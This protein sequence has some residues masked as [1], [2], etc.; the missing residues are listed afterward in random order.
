MEHFTNAGYM[1]HEQVW[2][3]VGSNAAPLAWA[4]AEYIKLVRSY[5]VKLAITIVTVQAKLM[6]PIFPYIRV[7]VR[8]LSFFSITVRSIL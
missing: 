1:I 3:N 7:P 8:I 2:D 5:Y 4:H 6:A